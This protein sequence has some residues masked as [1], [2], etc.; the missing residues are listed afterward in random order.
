MS[1]VTYKGIFL[2]QSL[3]INKSRK[4]EFSLILSLNNNGYLMIDRLEFHIG[5]LRL[6]LVLAMR[7]LPFCVVVLFLQS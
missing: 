2:Y 3:F 4:D 1:I 6:N 5:E 7:C